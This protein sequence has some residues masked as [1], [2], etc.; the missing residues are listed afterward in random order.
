MRIKIQ[1]YLFKC[2]HSWA[3]VGQNIGRAFLKQGH[4]VEFISSDGI[5]KKYIPDDLKPFI[6]ENPTGTYDCQVSYTAPHNWPKY[7]SH[8]TKNRFAI[9]NYEYNNK[10][11]ENGTSQTLLPGFAKFYQACDLVLPSSNFTKDVFKSMCIPEEKMVVVPHGINLNDFTSNNKTILQT[12][13]TKKI[14]LNIAQPHKRKALHLALESFGKAFTKNDDVCLIAKVLKSNHKNQQFD[15]NFNDLYKTFEQKFPNHANVEIVYNYVPNIA[16]LYK[17]CDINFS[18]TFA[19]CWHLPSLE[20]LAAGIINI[21]PRYGGQLDFC[22]DDNSL[23]IDVDIV[24][25]PKDHQYWIHSPYCVHGQIKTNDAAKKLQ[26]A[27]QDYDKLIAKFKNNMKNTV[28]KFTWE[29]AAKQIIN[30]CHG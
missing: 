3:V 12:K 30:L 16:D 10:K 13:K 15:V 8:G 23:L 26:M 7:L 28:E 9:W 22:N 2:S 6:K 19:E 29:N 25:A 27:V 24:R 17:A 14:L 18:A 20:A 4:T 21:V 5:D 1:Q 11:N